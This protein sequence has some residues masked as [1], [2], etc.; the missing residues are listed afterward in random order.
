MRIGKLIAATATLGGTGISRAKTGPGGEMAMPGAPVGTG[1]STGKGNTAVASIL[2]PRVLPVF[3][4]TFAERA[5]QFFTR[6]P[7]TAAK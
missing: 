6:C 3:A 1:E 7:D 4:G 5:Y 2:L